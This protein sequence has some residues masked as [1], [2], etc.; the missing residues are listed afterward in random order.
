[1]EAHDFDLATFMLQCQ[2]AHQSV[3][4]VPFTGQRVS[5]NGQV[6]GEPGM[7]SNVLQLYM[8]SIWLFSCY[9]AELCT[10]YMLNPGTGLDIQ[11][12]ARR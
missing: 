12:M 8:M 1:M 2:D 11:S 4:P 5:V 10:C 7:H 9:S 6:S 3:L